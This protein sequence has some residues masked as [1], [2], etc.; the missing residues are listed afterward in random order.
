MNKYDFKLVVR[1]YIYYIYLYVTYIN[2]CSIH[3][4]D[5]GGGELALL[6]FTNRGMSA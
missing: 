3:K 2:N 4:I 5:D 6:A 1:I